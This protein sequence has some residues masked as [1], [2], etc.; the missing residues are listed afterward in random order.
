MNIGLTPV[1]SYYAPKGGVQQ[2]NVN[3]GSG[4]KTIKLKKERQIIQFDPVTLEITNIVSMDDKKKMDPVYKKL[5]DAGLIDDEEKEKALPPCDESLL[6]TMRRHY[7]ELFALKRA[8]ETVIKIEE[9]QFKEIF[10]HMEAKDPEEISP[11]GVTE[12]AATRVDS[13]SVTE[14]AFRAESESESE[15][16]PQEG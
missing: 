10:D 9:D 11:E 1:Q 15:D 12:R 13:E 7:M 14:S 2:N 4:I 5:K 3:L 16:E 8:R 6:N